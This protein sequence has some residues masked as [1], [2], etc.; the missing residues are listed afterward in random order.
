MT[1]EVIIM[2]REAV[3]IAADSAVTIQ[4]RKVLNTANKLYMLAPG[5][6]V[7]VVIFNNASLMRVSW[8]LIIKL[9][10]DD[11]QKTGRRP[12]HLIDYATDFMNF[13]QLN[14][15]DWISEDEQNNYMNTRI[16]DL[17]RNGIEEMIKQDVQAKILRDARPVSNHDI[18]EIARNVINKICLPWEK[19]QNLYE[20]DVEKVSRIKQSLFD[21]YYLTFEKL[22]MQYLGKFSLEEAVK[23][24]LWDL[25]INWFIKDEWTHFSGIGFAGYGDND[26]FPSIVQYYVELYMNNILK[27]SQR[28]YNSGKDEV[29]IFPLAQT[30]VID[31]LISGIHTEGLHSLQGIFLGQISKRY[32]QLLASSKPKSSKEAIHKQASEM[33]Q[34]DYKVLAESLRNAVFDTYTLPIILMVQSLTKDELALMAE[35]LVSLTSYMRKVSPN[36]ETVGGP[37]DVA[38][39][40]KKDGFIWIKRKHYFN[41]EQ[42]YHFFNKD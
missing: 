20:G 27:F 37:T 7:G 31:T 16:E 25:C 19:Q 38:V 34:E 14:C 9:Y 35:T 2:N 32:E 21:K 30:D 40:S 41:P 33:A 18:S 23:N 17:M 13:V 15:Q 29:G 36:L 22:Y 5:H 3:A 8:E 28:E 12:S 24:R 1:T 26:L 4:N 39:I 6:A 11:L 42:N 10:R